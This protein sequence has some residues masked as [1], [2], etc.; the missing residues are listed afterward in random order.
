MK[1]ILSHSR[2]IFYEIY[3]FGIRFAI[4]FFDF[5]LKSNTKNLNFSSTP[6]HFIMNQLTEKVK[7]E[8]DNKYK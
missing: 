6:R 2:P 5:N 7:S 3:V 1:T 8:F 4:A